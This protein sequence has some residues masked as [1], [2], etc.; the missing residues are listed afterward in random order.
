MFPDTPATGAVV[1]VYVVPGF[2]EED[3]TISVKDPLQME[4]ALFV[5]VNTGLALTVIYMESLPVPHSFV[6]S[7]FIL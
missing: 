1:H 2:I 6:T 5:M 3:K 4:G 7:S